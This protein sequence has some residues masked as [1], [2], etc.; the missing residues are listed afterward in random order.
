MIW[1]RPQQEKISGSFSD[2]L[3]LI[4]EHK[5]KKM[6]IC[7]KFPC[8]GLNENDTNEV[9][10]SYHD[11]CLEKRK[12]YHFRKKYNYILANINSE[13]S[14][15]IFSPFFCLHPVGQRFLYPSKFC[16]HLKHS[17]QKLKKNIYIQLMFWF[18]KTVH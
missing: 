16:N 14:R 15:V 4:A 9:K 12:K 3:R 6:K 18:V 1:L 2:Y 10:R 7:L 8:L 11:D 17:A 13:S 5:N